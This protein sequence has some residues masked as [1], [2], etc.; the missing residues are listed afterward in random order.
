MNQKTSYSPIAV[1]PGLK[2]SDSFSSYSFCPKC[3]VD[4]TQFSHE[5]HCSQANLKI[6]ETIL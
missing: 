2:T 4:I 5:D 1:P 6:E 3:G